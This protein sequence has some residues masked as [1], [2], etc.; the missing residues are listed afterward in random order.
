[1]LQ[2]GL[3]FVKRGHCLFD[4]AVGAGEVP[5]I[6]SIAH[7]GECPGAESVGIRGSNGN[8]PRR[9]NAETNMR[10][11]LLG[12]VPT[13]SQT[14]AEWSFSSSRGLAEMD[15]DATAIAIVDFSLQP[16]TLPDI[17]YLWY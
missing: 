15:S 2:H 1:M 14:A 12:E 3:P 10:M 11:A 6:R 5:S 17:V 7:R 13:S 9:L 4:G 16:P 8:P